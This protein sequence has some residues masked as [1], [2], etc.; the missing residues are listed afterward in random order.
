MTKTNID[1]I[2]R[3]RQLGKKSDNDSGCVKMSTMFTF[4]L[5]GW[6]LQQNWAKVVLTLINGY[7]IYW[8][9]VSFCLRRV[10][11]FLPRICYWW[12][13]IFS[14]G[15]LIIDFLNCTSTFAVDYKT[16]E[17]WRQTKG[18]PLLFAKSVYFAAS[19]TIGDHSY[20]Y[21]V[22]CLFVPAINQLSYVLFMI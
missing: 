20:S 14:C 3:H 8:R 16:L 2:Q 6:V 21:V 19:C 17:V 7:W 1:E 5:W 11:I 18:M 22:R 10:F 15:W 9:W 12:S 4:S 13:F